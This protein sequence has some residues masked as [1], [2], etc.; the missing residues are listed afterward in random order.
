MNEQEYRERCAVR[1][2][3]Q[4]LDLVWIVVVDGR[5]QNIHRSEEGATRYAADLARDK[6]AEVHNSGFIDPHLQLVDICRRICD[7]HERNL[8]VDRS[9]VQLWNSL[10][11]RIGREL[12]AVDSYRV[13][14]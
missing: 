10:S 2:G 1:A 12:I 6:A 7:Q 4:R 11:E 5:T 9:I 8:E 13:E 14:D 3:D